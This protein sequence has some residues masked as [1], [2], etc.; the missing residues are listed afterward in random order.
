MQVYGQLANKYQSDNGRKF[1]GPPGAKKETNLFKKFP[2]VKL[3]NLKLA[4]DTELA[5]RLKLFIHE[6]DWTHRALTLFSGL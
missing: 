2:I 5:K 1:Q 6:S 4:S 3:K